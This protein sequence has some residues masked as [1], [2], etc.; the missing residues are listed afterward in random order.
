M[1]MTQ[2]PHT[3]DN[4]AGERLTFLGVREDEDGPVLDVRSVVEPGAGPPMHVHHLQEEAATVEAGRIGYVVEGGPEQFAG[5]GERVAFA[6]GVVHRFWNAGD[7]ELVLTGTIRPPGNVEYFLGEVF[8]STARTGGERPGF[9]DA[10]WLSHRYRTE[11]AMTE[12]PAPV[13]RL[14]FPLVAAAGRLLR[15]DRRFAGAPEPLRG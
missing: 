1:L 7:D 10:A 2:H 4:G 11:F 5:P 13:R 14:V 3:I 15:R 9:F 12:I 8:A 6:P